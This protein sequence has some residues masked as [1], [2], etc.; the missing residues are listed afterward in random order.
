MAIS[1][2]TITFPE[3]FE[4]TNKVCVSLKVKYRDN[5]RFALSAW[6]HFYLKTLYELG[7]G[8]HADGLKLMLESWAQHPFAEK[9]EIDSEIILQENRDP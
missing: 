1:F 4:S 6:I 2:A 7:K 5:P 3:E 9:D 8:V